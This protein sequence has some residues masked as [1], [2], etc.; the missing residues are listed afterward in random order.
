MVFRMKYPPV[1]STRRDAISAYVI[2][3]LPPIPVFGRPGVVGTTT[4]GGTITGVLP[5][6]VN[7]TEPDV[8]DSV[9]EAVTP[10][11]GVIVVPLEDNTA[12]VAKLVGLTVICK[13]D[14]A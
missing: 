2:S 11:V 8:G 13:P 9:P 7:T 12:F 3:A 14:P 4:T 1:A 6:P 5:T 10:A